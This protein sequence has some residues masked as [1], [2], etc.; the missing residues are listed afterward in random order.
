MADPIPKGTASV[1]AT[2]VMMAECVTR[3]RSWKRP[4]RGNHPS[5]KNCGKSI[6]PTNPPAS[7]SNDMTMPALMATDKPAA[8]KRPD[9]PT[10]RDVG[11]SGHRSDRSPVGSSRPNGLPGRPGRINQIVWKG[12]VSGFGDVRQSGVGKVIVNKF[13]ESGIGGQIIRFHIDV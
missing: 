12:D 10:T 8:R 11:A 5:A 13:N 6:L 4:R 2:V 7:P 1:M 9:V 3:A